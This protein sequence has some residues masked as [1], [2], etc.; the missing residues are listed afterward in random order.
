LKTTRF[1]SILCRRQVP[2]HL[3]RFGTS[4]ASN[5]Y[6]PL[7]GLAIALEIEPLI[8]RYLAIPDPLNLDDLT[9]R[10]PDFYVSG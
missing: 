6:P 2:E 5:N 7:G 9:V 4:N 10:S 1:L 3:S 8:I